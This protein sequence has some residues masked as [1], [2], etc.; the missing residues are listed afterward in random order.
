ME[1][2]NFSYDQENDDLFI[3]LKGARS[4]GAVEL[5]NFV[6]DFDEDENLVAIQIFEASQ[7][8]LKLLKKIVEMNK[9]K[10]FRAEVVNFRNMVMI[11]LEVSSED[12]NEE[13][14]MPIPRIKEKSGALNY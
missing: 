8:F 3:Y 9:I 6:F 1:R 10:E 14:V 7:V 5:G 12:D 4:F 2:F 13:I 11:R